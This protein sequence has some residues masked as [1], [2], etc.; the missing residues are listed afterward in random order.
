M[1]NN[2]FTIIGKSIFLPLL[3]VL[4]GLNILAQENLKKGK[5]LL[6]KEDFDAA[7]SEFTKCIATEKK[8]GIRSQCY[9][10]RAESQTDS[11]QRLSDINSALRLAP[12]SDEIY[13]RRGKYYLGGED[14]VNSLP[15]FTKAL[16]IN[17][18]NSMAYF[19]LGQIYEEYGKNRQSIKAFSEAIRLKTEMKSAYLLRGYVYSEKLKDY[20]KAIADFTKY[21]EFEPKDYEGFYARAAARQ[22]KG[23]LNK[24]K[25]DYETAIKLAPELGLENPLAT[26]T[27]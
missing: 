14:Y 16:K 11:R 7:Y 2:N 1:K 19:F 23:E 9:L 22:K 18:K 26:K 3:C 4:F 5:E 13:V 15:D 12:N 25:V 20:D 27:N 17:P 10:F 8:A 24:A 6:E 21:T